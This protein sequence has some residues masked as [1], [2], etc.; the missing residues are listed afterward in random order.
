VKGGGGDR[1]LYNINT[2]NIHMPMAW[3]MEGK[4]KGS[5][6]HKDGCSRTLSEHLK[7]LSN[8]K[9]AENIY[10]PKVMVVSSEGRKR[11]L[12]DKIV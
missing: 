4:G 9:D 8:E 10:A 12:A 7:V 3:G 11:T 1:I 6:E 2:Y 5:L